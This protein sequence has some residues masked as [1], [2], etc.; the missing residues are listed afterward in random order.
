[1]KTKTRYKIQTRSLH[2]WADIKVSEEGGP[3]K[4]ETYVSRKSAQAELGH[5]VNQKDY[6]I[7]PVATESDDDL[8]PKATPSGMDWGGREHPPSR[9]TSFWESDTVQFAWLISEIEAVGGFVASMRDGASTLTVL[10]AVAKEMDLQEEEVC[11]LIDR[12]NK[13]FEAIKKQL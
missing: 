5:F 3:Y 13:C 12:A 9:K 8:Y 1:M 2:G 4:L 11:Q 7:V 6:R 10:E